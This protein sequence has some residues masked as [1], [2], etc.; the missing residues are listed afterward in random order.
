MLSAEA[1]GVLDE[2]REVFPVDYYKSHLEQF[3]GF[4]CK[5]I[6]LGNETYLYQETF[7]KLYPQNTESFDNYLKKYTLKNIERENV[8]LVD[9]LNRWRKYGSIYKELIDSNI[10]IRKLENYLVNNRINSIAFYGDGEMRRFIEHMLRICKC[11]INYLIEDNDVKGINYPRYS[12]RKE[13]FNDV[14]LVIVTDV[15]ATEKTF[16]KIKRTNSNYIS[17]ENFLLSLS[18]V[19]LDI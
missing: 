16:N 4:L 18:N 10:L 14:D 2:F 7:Y 17:A 6:A 9:Y 12:R 13:Q 3:H 5:Q 11:N 1:E 15:F 8:R 19:Q